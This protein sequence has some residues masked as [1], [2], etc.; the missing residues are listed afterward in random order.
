M[1][2][3]LIQDAAS[4]VGDPTKARRLAEIDDGPLEGEFAGAHWN[5]VKVEERENGERVGGRARDGRAHA[6]GAQNFLA[7]PARSASSRHV[8]AMLSFCHAAVTGRL[9]P[10][11]PVK[12]T[13]LGGCRTRARTLAHRGSSVTPYLAAVAPNFATLV[14]LSIS[15]MRLHGVAVMVVR[16]CSTTS[17]RLAGAS[18]GGRE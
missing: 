11:S 13:G 7:G 16:S 9:C 5:G 4:Q 8:P 18:G 12:Y 2:L 3:G 15:P 17:S 14:R 10:P 1:G 6:L